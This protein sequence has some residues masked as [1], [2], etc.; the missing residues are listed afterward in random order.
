MLGAGEPIAFGRLRYTVTGGTGPLGSDRTS[1]VSA[2]DSLTYLVIVADQPLPPESGALVVVPWARN[3]RA[4]TAGLKTTSYADNVI[5]LARA[6]HSGAIEAVLGNTRGELCECTGSNVFV[7]IDG[8]IVTPPPESGLLEGITRELTLQWC[9]E[10]GI[11]VE[12]RTLPL[13]ILQT[14]DEVFITSSTKD[15]LAVHAV[16]DRRLEL[17]PVTA[18]GA[19]VFAARSAENVDP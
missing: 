3:E 17:G 4:P 1:P 18:R 6:R 9:R 8:T 5:A 19:K 7:V 12:E 11:P 2:R 15:L 16:D 10:D 14:A 13:D